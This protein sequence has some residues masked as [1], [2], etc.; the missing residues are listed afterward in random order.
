MIARI[1]KLAGWVT[2]MVVVCNAALAEDRADAYP[3]R[4][5]RIIISVAP[6]AGADFVAR[7]TADMFRDAWGQNAVV[8]SRPGGAGVVA[9]K[10]TVQ[11]TPDGHTILQ[12]GNGMLML[13]AQ[14]RVPFDVLKAFE[15]IVAQ[16]TQPYII[17]AHES[18]QANT[19][20]DLVAL[21]AAKPLTYAGGGGVGSTIHVGMEQLAS[22]SGVK[23]KY[24]PYKGSAP[25][26]LALMGGEV[27]LTTASAMA[28]SAAIRTGKVRGIA[29]T[30]LKRIA[31]L[32]DLPTVAEQGYPGFSLTNRYHLWAPAGTPPAIVAKINRVV[33]EGMNAPQAVQKL[34][35]SGSGPAERMTPAQLKASLAQEY[36]EVARVAA[37]IASTAR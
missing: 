22:L 8:D 7:M 23:L 18:I 27:N 30:G 17:L 15:P 9:V 29:T 36:V 37:Q 14:K 5:I 31:V 11:A 13:G 16:T 12:F 28:G 26:I 1:G 4:P 34:A 35:A 21:S 2:P 25:S 6:G 20:K 32:P 24:I 3:E 33:I 10:L 19:V